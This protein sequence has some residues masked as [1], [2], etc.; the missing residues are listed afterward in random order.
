MPFGV[1]LCGLCLTSAWL[2][3]FEQ[4]REKPACIHKSAWLPV[5]LYSVYT[6]TRLN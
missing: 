3:N 5:A 1:R 4:N 6:E 2:I